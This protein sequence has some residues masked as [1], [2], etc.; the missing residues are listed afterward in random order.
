MKKSIK[1]FS[2]LLIALVLI[3]GCGKKVDKTAEYQET[4][5]NYAVSYWTQFQKGIKG[6]NVYVV[7]LEELRRIAQNPKYTVDYDL[8]KLEDCKDDTVVNL[9]VNEDNTE[10]LEKEAVMNCEK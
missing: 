10:I 3:T 2:V 9:T 1:L 6:V 5:E 4:M 7:S 8:T